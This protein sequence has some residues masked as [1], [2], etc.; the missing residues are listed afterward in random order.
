MA[1]DKVDHTD[2]AGRA[3]RSLLKAYGFDVKELDRGGTDWHAVAHE[4]AESLSSG[5]AC[6]DWEKPSLKD[7]ATK[8]LEKKAPGLL[9]D[10][11]LEQARRGGP[12]TGLS[13]YEIQMEQTRRANR[14]VA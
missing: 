1:P 13:D 3:F 12:V 2:P 11:E 9:T 6:R 5:N 8:V 7:L 14:R 10:A 4:L